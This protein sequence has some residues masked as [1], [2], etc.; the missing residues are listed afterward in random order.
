M[1][2]KE[3]K[4]RADGQVT[5]GTEEQGNVQPKAWA[6]PGGIQIIRMGVKRQP[7]NKGGGRSGKALGL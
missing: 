2:V 7:A 3:P 1:C 5:P 6:P 4:D